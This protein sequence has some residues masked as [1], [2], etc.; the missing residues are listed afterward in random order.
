[1]ESLLLAGGRLEAAKA[2]A[3]RKLGAINRDIR[4]V[5]GD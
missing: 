5:I 3:A 2:E 4:A 1:M